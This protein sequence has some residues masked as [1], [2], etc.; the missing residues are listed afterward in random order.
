MPGLKINNKISDEILGLTMY[1][2]VECVYTKT[3]QSAVE[4]C[5][6]TVK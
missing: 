4:S 3:A 2:L 6:I 5:I 1:D